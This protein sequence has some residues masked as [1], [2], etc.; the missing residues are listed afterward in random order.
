MADVESGHVCTAQMTAEVWRACLGIPVVP[1]SL[2]LQGLLSSQYTLTPSLHGPRHIA[3]QALQGQTLGSSTM[4]IS[5][6]FLSNS[7]YLPFGEPNNLGKSDT[8]PGSQ[9]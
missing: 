7:I 6:F 1:P 2:E 9:R 4:V 5:P 8:T 3:W